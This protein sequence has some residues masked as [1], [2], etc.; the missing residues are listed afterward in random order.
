MT[1]EEITREKK[2]LYLRGYWKDHKEEL[3]A[4]RKLY[5]QEHKEEINRKGRERYRM[6]KM[7]RQEE[8]K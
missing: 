7:Q 8:N 2:R 6:R 4:K 5:Y 1:A 3:T